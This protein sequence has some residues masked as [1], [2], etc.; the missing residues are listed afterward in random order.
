MCF[1]EERSSADWLLYGLILEKKRPYY[2]ICLCCQKFK[3]I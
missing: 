1:K 2:L 3:Q